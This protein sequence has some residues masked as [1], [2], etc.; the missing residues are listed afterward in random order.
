MEAAQLVECFLA[1]KLPRESWTHEAHL[2]VGLWHVKNFRRDALA[3][4][5]DRITALNESNGVINSDA[6]GYHETLTAFYVR[7]ISAFLD[8]AD[9]NES[10]DALASRL[11]RDF[12][13]REL[14]LRYYSR[15]ELFSKRARRE[16]V[17]PDMRD[18]DF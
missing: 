15:Q 14:P 8:R 2:K 5:R 3:L 10:L 6:E 18:F 1:R 17:D 7:V 4:L 16:W 9:S 12:G 13:D 11:I